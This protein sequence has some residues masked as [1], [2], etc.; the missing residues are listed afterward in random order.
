MKCLSCGQPITNENKQKYKFGIVLPYCKACTEAYNAEDKTIHSAQI[1]SIKE[2]LSNKQKKKAHKI[3]KK[4]LM[5]EL[6]LSEAE[7]EE[8]LKEQGI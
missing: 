5:N 8:H 4:R 3:A 1:Q 7:A 6:N 2:N